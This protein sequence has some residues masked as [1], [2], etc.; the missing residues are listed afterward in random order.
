MS[1][2]G[3]RP[4]PVR[5]PTRKT[6]SVYIL[7]TTHPLLRTLAETR[8]TTIGAL[9]DELVAAEAARDGIRLGRAS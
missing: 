4:A 1:L 6:L 8:G 5:R 3:R 9:V 7:P 2:A